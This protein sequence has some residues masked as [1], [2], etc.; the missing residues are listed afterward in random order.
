MPSPQA[1]DPSPLPQ[2]SSPQPHP[3]PPGVKPPAPSPRCQAPS[4]PSKSRAP[5]PLP[6]RCPAPGPLPQFPGPPAQPPGPPLPV[7]PA[8]GPCRRHLD[9]VLRRLQAA[10]FRGGDIYIPNCDHRGHYRRRQCKSS[11]GQ[12]RGPC[13]CVDRKGQPLPS[14]AGPDSPSPCPPGPSS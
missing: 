8:Q 7:P 2:V 13:W 4:P 12:R 11:T 10:V 14:P 5:S 3:P 1:P 6:R 9:A